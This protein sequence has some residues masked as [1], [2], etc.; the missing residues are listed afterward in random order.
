MGFK[1]I[2]EAFNYTSIRLGVKSNYVKLGRDEF[3]AVFPWRRGWQRKL[4]NQITRTIEVFQDLEMNEIF[5]IIKGVL[6]DSDYLK[7]E[8]AQEIREILST[9]IEDVDQKSKVFILR[10]PTG[11]K[12]ESIL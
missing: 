3:D 8:N 4:D 5:P 2:N 6:F 7:S 11:L 10:S 12:G 1:T 9:E